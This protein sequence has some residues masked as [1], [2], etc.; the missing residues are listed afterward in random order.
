MSVHALPMPAAA[1]SLAM[2]EETDP[3]AAWIVVAVLVL[4]TTLAAVLRVTAA[5]E[6]LVVRRRRGAARVRGPGPTFV[7]PGLERGA[8]ISLNSRELGPVWVTARTADAVTAHLAVAARMQV[9]DPTLATAADPA[10]R[11]VTVLETSV[12]AELARLGVATL[13]DRREALEQAVTARCA[14]A[15]AEFGTRVTGVDVLEIKLDLDP[16]L[17]EWVGRCVGAHEAR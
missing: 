14:A 6:R 8:R 10:C 3:L 11:A 15:A 9:V 5:D 12:S 2:H 13:A 17:I 7:I 1:G 16:H 4:G